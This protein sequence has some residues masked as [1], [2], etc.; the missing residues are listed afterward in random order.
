MRTKIITRHDL[1]KL[2]SR[3][4]VLW[5]P[6]PVKLIRLDK[7]IDYYVIYHPKI[8][9]GYF[10]CLNGSVP[11]SPLDSD[12]LKHVILVAIANNDAWANQQR[13]YDRRA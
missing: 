7:P 11:L 8:V 13:L 5:I 6:V 12:I 1:N 2:Y 4:L 9:T 10:Q 3:N